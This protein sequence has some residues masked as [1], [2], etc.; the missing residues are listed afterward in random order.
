MSRKQKAKARATKNKWDGRRSVRTIEIAGTLRCD[1]DTAGV[2]LERAIGIIDL[3]IVA[4]EGVY[5][6]NT[7]GN[8][9]NASLFTALAEVE[10]AN[11][12]IFGR[13]EA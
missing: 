4:C 5:I 7:Q 9:L 8:T 2:A 12:A 10:R 1:L 11:D 6:P 13:V 3:L